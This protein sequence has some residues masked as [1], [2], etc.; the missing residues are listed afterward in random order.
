MKPKSNIFLYTIILSV[1]MVSCTNSV[2]TNSGVEELV[3]DDLELLSKM[4]QATLLITELV[5]KEQVVKEIQYAVAHSIEEGRDEDVT[6][7]QL[8]FEDAQYK[9]ALKSKDE[10]IIGS[11]RNEFRQLMS[12]K[13]KTQGENIDEDLENYLIQNNLKLYW[14]YSEN[15]ENQED[16]L[17][18]LSYHPLIN[19]DENEGFLP[20]DSKS[21]TTLPYETVLMND[22]YAFNNP[23]LLIVPCE[24]PQLKV[25][26]NSAQSCG[27][28][29]GGGSDPGD[30]D[31]VDETEPGEYEFNKIKIGQ[32]RLLDHYDGLF[33]GG[34]EVRWQLAD[35]L[36]VT[37]YDTNPQMGAGYCP[38]YFKRIDI[39]KNRWKDINCVIDDDWSDYE[40]AKEL[41]IWEGDE[42]DNKIKL[43]LGVNVKFSDK[44][45]GSVG[46]EISADKSRDDIY[47]AFKVRELFYYEN[48]MDGGNGIRNGFRV[49]KADK[50]LWTFVEDG[51]NINN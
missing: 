27:E 40:L 51:I 28:L 30:D 23:S 33:A 37:T 43:N 17:P 9:V 45:T 21:K 5:K 34:S 46:V 29:G 2:N 12:V 31:P 15:W 1:L 41:Y 20:I 13:L 4:K 25:V 50:L 10:S 7:S 47:K 11:F 42:G 35:A 48:T 38:K 44:V 16:V 49:R 6:F 26:V 18:T 24:I 14:P 3:V 36:F 19:E 22:E 39:R 32:S 8:F